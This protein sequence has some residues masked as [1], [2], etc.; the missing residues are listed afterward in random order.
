MEPNVQKNKNFQ[1]IFTIFISTDYEQKVQKQMIEDIKSVDQKSENQKS[2]NSESPK[3]GESF[4]T[5]HRIP[6]ELFSS[7]TL[8]RIELLP[9]QTTVQVCNSSLH[10][11][12]SAVK[13]LFF[14]ME[15][16]KAFYCFLFVTS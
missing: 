9:E 12:V 1:N 13:K 14:I 4:I 5:G 11:L 8:R 6:L 10:W 15:Y 7:E 16:T 2:E 3:R